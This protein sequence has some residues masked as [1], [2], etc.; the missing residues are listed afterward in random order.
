MWCL[1]SIILIILLMEVSAL[2]ERFHM[3]IFRGLQSSRCRDPRMYLVKAVS[4][5][6][7]VLIEYQWAKCFCTLNPSW[8]LSCFKSVQTLLCRSLVLCSLVGLS[9]FF[10][11]S[12]AFSTFMRLV[13]WVFFVFSL[14]VAL[15]KSR[16]L[17]TRP[18]FSGTGQ[19]VSLDTEY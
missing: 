15:L 9:L 12:S 4:V 18:F 6:I 2:H 10:Y 8:P 3:H 1:L 11:K 14:I 7:Q 5:K 17:W 19:A 16:R 13:G